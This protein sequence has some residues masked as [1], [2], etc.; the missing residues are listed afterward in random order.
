MS[1][2][3]VCDAPKRLHQAPELERPHSGAGQHGRE[4]EVVLR[5]DHHDVI[6]VGIERFQHR[7]AAPA[8]AQ[9]HEARLVLVTDLL[10]IVVV[11]DEGVDDGQ[12]LGPAGARVER[13]LRHGHLGQDG[14]LGVRGGVVREKGDDQRAREEDEEAAIGERA[15]EEAEDGPAEGQ[16]LG[17]DEAGR[18]AGKRSGAE[19]S[20]EA[21][22]RQSPSLRRPAPD[23]FPQSSLAP[24]RPCPYRLRM[25]VES[26][27]GGSGAPR[28]AP[29]AV[30]EHS[31]K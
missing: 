26:R 3:P 7:H 29:D 18:G 13:R 19:G 10:G 25:N 14:G 30:L 8:A 16:G 4:A 27:E 12:V 6:I 15:V 5:A 23:R 21:N 1:S 9:H 31:A 2:D 22:A 24:Q 17:G 11:V 28:G 20:K